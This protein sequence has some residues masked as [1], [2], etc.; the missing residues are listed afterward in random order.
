MGKMHPEAFIVPFTTLWWECIVMV[1][2]IITIVVRIPFHFKKI[3]P[4]TYATFIAL[5]FSLNFIVANYYNYQQG[6]WNLQ[7][8]LPVHLCSISYFMCIALLLNYKQWLAECV[9]YWGLAGGIHSILTPEFTVGMDGY[10]FYAYFIDHAG[11]LLVIAYMI[12][13]LNFRPRPRSWIWIFG[14]TQLVAIG[15]GIINYMVGANY[16][17]LSQKPAANNPFVIGEWPYYII[18]L[19]L[20]ALMHFWVFYLPFSKK[21]KQAVANA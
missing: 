1:I 6:Y 12:I 15:V 16:M 13:H 14:Y 18:V 17:Y 20:V 4:K 5:F 11:M 7:Q 8:N 3:K 2:L 9:Y 10:N 19:E 21:N